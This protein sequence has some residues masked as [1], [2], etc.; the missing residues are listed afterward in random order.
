MDQGDIVQNMRLVSG[1]NIIPDDPMGINLQGGASDQTLILYDQIPLYHTQH[2][3]GFNGLLNADCIDHLTLYTGG[4]PAKFGDRLSGVLDV[5][6]R[7]GKN[8]GLHARNNF[9]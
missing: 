1:V 7:S 2:L 9:V 6:G 4:Y 8:E 3:M 5:V